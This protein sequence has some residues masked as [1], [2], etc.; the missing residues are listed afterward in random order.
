[1]RFCLTQATKVVMDS[2]KGPFLA[3]RMPLCPVQI[4]FPAKGGSSLCPTISF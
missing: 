1:L 2:K 4:E 3:H